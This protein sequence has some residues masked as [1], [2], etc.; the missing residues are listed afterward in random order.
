MKFGFYTRFQISICQINRW[1]KRKHNIKPKNTKWPVKINV[2]QEIKYA[3]KAK[4]SGYKR[5]RRKNYTKNLKKTTGCMEK[6]AMLLIH[7]SIQSCF[8]RL[9]C[10]GQ[11]QYP[12]FYFFVCLFPWMFLC[13]KWLNRFWQNI[14]LRVEDFSKI[15]LHY[16]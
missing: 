13:R 6:N 16:F 1:T 9:Y 11:K 14:H 4:W 8:L 3:N 12:I 10:F 15:N 2:A 5:T 7:T